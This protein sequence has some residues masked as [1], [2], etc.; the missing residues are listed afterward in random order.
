M[1]I[2]DKLLDNNDDEN[3]ND[4]N[5][6]NKSIITTIEH[7]TKDKVTMTMT[8]TTTP[9]LTTTR[10]KQDGKPSLVT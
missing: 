10:L 3:N 1:Q 4:D 5:S 2:H 6:N 7:C 9:M 8:S